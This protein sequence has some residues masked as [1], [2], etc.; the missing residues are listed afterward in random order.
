RPPDR[1]RLLQL[2]QRGD[3]VGERDERLGRL[4]DPVADEE[5]VDGP[6]PGAD[7][8]GEEV[9]AREGP[10]KEGADPL[11]IPGGA[12][13]REDLRLEPS[14]EPGRVVP[15]GTDAAELELAVLV[16]AV[17]AVRDPEAVRHRRQ[18]DQP[19]VPSLVAQ[20]ETEPLAHSR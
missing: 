7:L 16:V 18:E 13:E 9:G 8:R 11:R 4:A 20:R 1:P 3:R 14:H 17:V 5:L 12:E 10:R 6:R 2:T 15:A 19:A